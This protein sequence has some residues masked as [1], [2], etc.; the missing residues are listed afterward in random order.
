MKITTA[1]IVAAYGTMVEDRVELGFEPTLLTFTFNPLPGSDRAK[2][3]TM[4]EEIRAT[5]Y[6]LL[7]RVIRNP[8]NKNAL[9]KPFWVGGP[10]WPVPKRL[11]DNYRDTA[12]NDG[13]HYHMVAL[14]PP[15]TR[16]NGSLGAFITDNQRLYTGRDRTLFRIHV[17]PITADPDYVTEYVFK[18]I[19]RG[20]ASL[21]SVLILPD[22]R[23]EAPTR[24][25]WERQQAKA[26]GAQR[27][28]KPM[29]S[30]HRLSA[31][32]QK[33]ISRNGLD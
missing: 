27:R 10:D 29:P 21:D 13:L 3:K 19:K 6:K 2:E 5:Y 30:A 8:N 22:A 32:A 33:A 14:T 31:Q 15:V 20:R 17:E 11:K 7:T 12:V 18:S 24:T 25:R 4:E 1:D 9:E 23:S 26:E 28:R 16:L